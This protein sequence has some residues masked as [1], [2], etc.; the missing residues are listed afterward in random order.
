MSRSD[1]QVLPYTLVISFAVLLFLYP[2]P[3]TVGARTAL[4]FVALFCCLLIL[5]SP[6][7][8][9]IPF[10][11]ISENLYPVFLSPEIIVFCGLSIWIFVRT[12]Y[13]AIIK[14]PDPLIEFLGE[15][16]GGVIVGAIFG[17]LV[18]YCAD[19]C[20][21]YRQLIIF[22]FFGLFL[23]V[24][25]TLFFQASLGI[26][27]ASFLGRVPYTERDYLSSIVG[28]VLPALGAYAFFYKSSTQGEIFNNS[29]WVGLGFILSVVL[30]ATLNTR[31]GVISSFSFVVLLFFGFYF[32]RCTPRASSARE[33]NTGPFFRS[34]IILIA[35]VI[36]A[37]AA[38]LFLD[39]RWSRFVSTLNYMAT[40]VE[41]SIITPTPSE[42]TTVLSHP[43]IEGSLGERLVYLRLGLN[44]IP[45]YP[46]G[47]GY[48]REAF[49][50]AV[51]A[52][53]GE[54]AW[55]SS[56]SGLVDFTLANGIPGLLLWLALSVI[57]LTRFRRVVLGDN[58]YGITIVSVWAVFFTRTVLDGHFSGW[59]L[60]MFALIVGL[61]L[62]GAVRHHK[63]QLG[64]SN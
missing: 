2:V 14:T 11:R 48:G 7:A 21:V 42:F 58:I 31:N 8:P 9:T 63:T 49:G 50:N 28:F 19:R 64:R 34:R 60:R 57:V 37:F 53:Y 39:A 36:L 35:L 52:R 54:S 17:G 40:A 6:S 29:R 10:P 44:E 43:D 18:A 47:I 56:H 5:R 33:E 62:Y 51:R 16:V 12:S 45:K 25:F 27:S 46:F 1:R 3:G 20:G 59:R 32:L 24:M 41:P 61:L 30:T 55:V 23:H 4:F 13:I 22:V 26:H 15:W 38:T